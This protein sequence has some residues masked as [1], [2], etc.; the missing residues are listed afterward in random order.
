MDKKQRV[1]LKLFAFGSRITVQIALQPDLGM[2]L[3][4]TKNVA[5]HL[6]LAAP[7]KARNPHED[8]I[9]EPGSRSIV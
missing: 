2:Q 1:A 5:G 9:S 3:L 8:F 6:N 7:A 4:L